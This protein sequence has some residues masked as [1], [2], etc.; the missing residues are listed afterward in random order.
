MHNISAL[1]SGIALLC[2]I[3]APASLNARN[4]NANIT[5]SVSDITLSVRAK[6][7]IVNTYADGLTRISQL[8][9]ETGGDSRSLWVADTL[10]A[11]RRSMYRES[12]NFGKQMA[13]AYVM[14]IYTTYG[15]I[16]TPSI[17]GLHRNQKGTEQHANEM[18]HTAD[19]LYADFAKT[20]YNDL[21][22]LIR[23]GCLAN[24]YTQLYAN[25][26]NNVQGVAVFEQ[27]PIGH[28]L[29]TLSIIDEQI[30]S[31][32]NATEVYQ[33][34]SVM[35][36]TSFY[37]AWCTLVQGFV[38]NEKKFE[39]NKKKLSSMADFYAQ[40]ASKVGYMPPKITIHPINSTDFE[41]YTYDNAKHKNTLLQLFIQNLKS[42][43]L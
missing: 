38:E 21:Y 12:F 1:L 10:Q 35:E 27:A 34:A 9:P 8:L 33:L 29:Y 19:S 22:K 41:R 28:N 3:I 37:Q 23:L 2:L 26:A 18:L 4:R 42:K 11:I 6:Q 17:M 20:Y 40:A 36:G 7:K 25:I 39:S 5:L 31:N 30:H 16:Y 14:Q 24:Y 32:H 43:K 15:L 13:Q